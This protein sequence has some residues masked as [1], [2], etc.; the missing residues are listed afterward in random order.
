MAVRVRQPLYYQQEDVPYQQPTNQPNTSKVKK[1]QRKIITAREKFL[2]IAFVIVVATLSVFVLHK[3][4]SI[5]KTTIEIQK[6][7]REIAEIE[8]ENADL[9]VQVSELSTYERIW[10]KANSLG[11]TLKEDNVKV[12][13]GE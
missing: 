13:P 3:Q 5:Q 9:K 11:L 1:K 7:E 6:I 12:V 8:K 10:E 4:S 2:Y